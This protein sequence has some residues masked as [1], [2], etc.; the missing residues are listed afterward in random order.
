M[1]LQTAERVSRERSDNFVFQ[2]S[3]LA[4]VE[5]ARRVGG[6][7][8]EIGTGTGYGIEIIAPSAESFVTLD[9]FRSSEVESLPRGV[10]FREATVPPLP[11]DDESFD[12]VV[13][14]QVIEHIKRDRAFVGEVRRVLKRGGKFIVSTPNRPMSLTRNP[15]HVREYTAEEFS[16]LLGNFSAVEAL[17]VKGNERVWRYYEKNRESVRRIMRFDI[18][19]MQWW[20]P[21]WILQLPYDVL[22]RLNRRRLHSANVELTESICLEDYYL[23]KVD[24]ECFDLFYIAT[25]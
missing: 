12:C 20:L 2:R 6:R 10:E 19:R 21:R 13:S 23:D 15:W 3:R 18:L 24:N 7:V 4:Y 11:F 1:A 16:A 25:K 9:K 5:A 17:G 22:N 8:L 14:F